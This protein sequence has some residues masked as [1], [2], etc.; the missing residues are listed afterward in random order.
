MNSTPHPILLFD[1]IC[2]LCNGAVQW[3]IERDPEGLFRFASLQSEAGQALLR[4]HGLST[5]AI[6]TVV[7]IDRG[8]VYTRSDAAL[9]AAH[10]LGGAWKLLTV[11]TY[12]PRTFRNTVY[13][14]IARNRY[15]WFGQREQCMIPTPELKARFL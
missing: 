15:R 1:G 12:L 14:W 7:L 5:T 9:R 10:H 8:R 2:N 4:Q 6:D 3:I 11:F 13:D